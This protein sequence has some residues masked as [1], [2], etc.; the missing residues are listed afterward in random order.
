[1]STSCSFPDGSVSPSNASSAQRAMI[2]PN[3]RR[4]CP[5]CGTEKDSRLFAAANFDL[6]RLNDFTFASRKLPEHMHLRLLECRRCDLLYASPAF[7]S[8]TLAVAYRDA[9]YDSVAVAQLA[10]QTYARY[11]PGL[12]ARLPSLEGALDIGAGDGGFLEQLLQ[13]GFTNATGVEPSLAAVA[14]ARPE[15]KKLIRTAMFDRRDF[16]PESLSLVTCFQTIEHVERPLSLCQ[17]TFHL[18]RPGGAL[19]LI[20]HNRRSFSARLL[21]RKSPIF[22]IEHLQLFSPRSLSSLLEAAGYRDVQVTTIVN[23]YPLSYWARLFPMPA[24]IKARFIRLLER[25]GV[26]KL[27][28]SLPAGNIAAV[29]Y[30][31]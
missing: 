14:T 17:E 24:A 7:A 31:P 20:G 30:K 11:L 15:I 5:I 18:L 12:I 3:I 26:G 29:G 16:V 13:H 4:A 25:T 2:E 8:G 28:L 9:A 23:R 21:G 22:D 10:A 19:F 6:D 27:K 1:M